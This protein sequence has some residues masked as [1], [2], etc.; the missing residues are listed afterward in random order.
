M[1][2]IGIYRITSPNS[3]IYIGQSWDMGSR[4]SC[5]KSLNNKSQ[6]RLFNSI[7][8]YGA[9]AHLFEVAHE[10]PKDVCQE[11]M[12]AYEN[13]YIDAYKKAGFE[14]MNLR[15]GGANGKFHS[16]AKRLMS[17]RKREWIKAN[18]EKFRHTI[19]N[20]NAWVKNNPSHAEH[21]FTWRQNNLEESN[22]IINDLHLS[23]K[24]AI[25]Q[26]TINGD[27]VREWV[28]IKDA[29]AHFS[30]NNGAD[31]NIIKCLKGRNKIAYGYV[32]FY[33]GKERVI[34]PLAYV[35]KKAIIQCTLDN[36]LIKEHESIRD[37]AKNTGIDRASISRCANGHK[38]QKHAGGFIWKYK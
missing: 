22:N 6:R 31:G 38:W 7:N 15:D 11:V 10:L 9:N 8:K 3:S 19:L 14:V 34:N 30:K 13:I 24:K 5:H 35:K 20:I 28:G 16:D 33:K 25:V 18:P 17:D 4:F 37:A 27:F 21:M 32:W 23:N 2:K 26:Y 29:A 12:D 1:A 36:I